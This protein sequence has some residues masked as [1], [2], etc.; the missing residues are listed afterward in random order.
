MEKFYLSRSR[1]KLGEGLEE[2]L[3]DLTNQ[4]KPTKIF[5]LL[6]S[7]FE[8]KGN[9]FWVDFQPKKAEVKLFNNLVFVK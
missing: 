9:L 3:K 8:K 4:I 2:L 6:E 7:L 1:L 5:F